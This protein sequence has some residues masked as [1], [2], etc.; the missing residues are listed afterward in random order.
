MDLHLDIGR[1]D[2]SCWASQS[3]AMAAA[4]ACS[5]TLRALSAVNS[6]GVSAASTVSMTSAAASSTSSLHPGAWWWGRRRTECSRRARPPSSRGRLTRMS[7]GPGVASRRAVK[8]THDAVLRPEPSSGL[9]Q[10]RPTRGWSPPEHLGSRYLDPTQGSHGV[11]GSDA[12]RVCGPP[13]PP[14]PTA[15]RVPDHRLGVHQRVHDGSVS[16][17]AH[18][19]RRSR[20]PLAGRATDVAALSGTTPASR[21]LG[22]ASSASPSPPL[23]ASSRTSP[24]TGSTL[25]PTP[26]RWRCAASGAAVSHGRHGRAVRSVTALGFGVVRT[27]ACRGARG[28]GPRASPAPRARRPA[29]P[30]HRSPHDPVSVAGGKPVCTEPHMQILC[31]KSRHGYALVWRALLQEWLAGLLRRG[32]SRTA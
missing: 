5:S 16:S 32:P 24:V 17:P 26:G 29:G 6:P 12:R 2:R 19:P 7:G 21:R 14:Q 11:R 1:Q 27:T 13:V 20:P 30:A 23:P 10:V 18:P 3:A 22:S 9:G 8:R 25:T 4:G 31:G 15:A 28:G